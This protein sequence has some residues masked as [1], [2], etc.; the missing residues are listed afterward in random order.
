M[1]RPK[2]IYH[3]TVSI[4]GK[5]TGDYLSA[6]QAQDAIACYYDKHREFKS[7]GFICGRKTMESS[8]NSLI[9]DNAI[10]PELPVESREDFIGD[11][12][13]SFYAIALDSKGKLKWIGNTLIDEDPGYDKA[14]IIEV[15]CEDADRHY[16]AYL[17][18]RKISYVFAGKNEIDLDLL[19]RKLK[20]LFSI[21]LL[22]L[23]GG[24]I[25]GGSFIA[26]GLVDELSLVVAPVLQGGAGQDLVVARAELADKRSNFEI[27][28]QEMVGTNTIY[29][30]YRKAA[31]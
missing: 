22:L 14:H 24:G 23:E 31:R 12:D 3:M 11:P 5:I 20:E 9:D 13:A 27:Q 21:E 28:S 19:T 25:I 17:Q 6:P 29:L 7:D 1:N 30:R 16:L 10:Y 2:V 8:F 15:L 26:A 4:D 18:E